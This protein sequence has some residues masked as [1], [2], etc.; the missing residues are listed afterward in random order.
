[1]DLD[2]RRPPSEGAGVGFGPVVV[3][4]S[5]WSKLGSVLLLRTRLSTDGSTTCRPRS[6]EPTVPLSSDEP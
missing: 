2:V 6:L 5:L 1:M 3:V 4:A